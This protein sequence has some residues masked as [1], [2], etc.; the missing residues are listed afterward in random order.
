[1][2]SRRPAG[3]LASA[4][5]SAVVACA[6]SDGDGDGSSTGMGAGGPTV[7]EQGDCSSCMNGECADEVCAEP[8]GVCAIHPECLSL[9]DCWGQCSSQ[10]ASCFEDCEG[11][12]PTG[13]D[14]LYGVYTCLIC[15]ACHGDCDGP[16]RCG[17]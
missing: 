14:H 17:G 3:L 7:C 11:L 10:D 4:L 1:M 12:H 15:Q 2:M 9:N 6:A 13:V 5:L 8:I 16:S